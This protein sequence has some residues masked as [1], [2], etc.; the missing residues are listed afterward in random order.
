MCAT[1]TTQPDGGSDYVFLC[2][3]LR[4]R[5]AW[6]L[7]LWHIWH[8]APICTTAT[9]PISL[10]PFTPCSFKLAYIPGILVS[11]SKYEELE[12]DCLGNENGTKV[13]PFCS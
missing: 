3:Y 6:E 1:V 8:R 13:K 12:L 5:R 7:F 9:A 11:D 4:F 2:S 10:N